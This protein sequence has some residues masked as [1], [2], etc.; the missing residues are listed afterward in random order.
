[1]HLLQVEI[2]TITEKKPMHYVTLDTP[3]EHITRFLQE[4]NILAVPGSSFRCIFT[5][6]LAFAYFSISRAV[7]AC[8]H[9]RT[10]RSCS[11]G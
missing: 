7:R 9:A 4:K 2:G 1:M 5:P 3:L 8:E 10:H 11:V 6:S